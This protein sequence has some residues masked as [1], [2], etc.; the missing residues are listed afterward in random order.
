MCSLTGQANREYPLIDH[1]LYRCSELN[2]ADILI[3]SPTF[4]AIPN[5][6]VS[7]RLDIGALLDLR[8]EATFLGLT[9]FQVLC[10][11]EIRR[12]ATVAPSVHSMRASVHSNL[13][14][15]T[16]REMQRPGPGTG[17]ARDT[18]KSLSDGGVVYRSPPTP[19][20]WT[21]SRTR[22]STST[23]SRRSPAG[24]I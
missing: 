24:W 22:E 10:A 19:Q 13:L 23:S 6:P 7:P 1:R 20:S 5:I 2:S 14:E 18:E 21:K 16:G 11:E 3:S 8:D 9:G 17:A 15:R 12:L 4:V